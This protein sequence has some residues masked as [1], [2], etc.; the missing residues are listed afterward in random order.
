MALHRKL[1]LFYIVMYGIGIIVGAGVYALLGTAAGIAGNGLWISFAIGAILASFTGLSYAELSS[2]YPKASAEANYLKHAFRKDWIAFAVGW[3][4]A[5]VGFVSAGAVALGFA[6]Y[7]SAFIPLPPVLVAIALIFFLSII[8]FLGIETSAKFNAVFTIIEVIGVIII[9]LIGIPFFGK[10]NY[11]ELAN[12]VPGIFSATALIFFA[13]IGFEAIAKLG[14]ETKEAQKMLPKALLLSIAITS[15]LYILLAIS[16]V[17][18]MPVSELSQT[19][20]PLA[21]L[22]AKAVSPG[23]GVIV[24]I[25]ALL[26]TFSTVLVILIVTSRLLYGLGQ[27]HELPRIISRVHKKTGTPYIAIIATA[28]G[29][30]A[31]ALI[32][33]IKI[34]ADATTF[35]IFLCFFAV[36][37]AL[38]DLRFHHK[39]YKPVFKAPLNIGRFSITAAIGAISSFAMLF[40][41]TI[42]EVQLTIVFVGT[43]MVIYLLE[44]HLE[45]AN[46]KKTTV[47]KKWAARA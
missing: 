42:M 15:I 8:N 13:Y 4:V 46:R 29:A 32:G 44:K 25:I 33:D 35:M 16:A 7:F 5:V 45:K 23:F 36:N 34:V 41:Y 12:G 17:S 10:V 21:D 20:A 40:S 30:S 47:K 27:K 22:A 24:A 28:I 14:E 43:G 18:I 26:A 37:I 31:M 3:L 11:F 6:G 19:N 38:L 9:I 39:W 2:A 1:G